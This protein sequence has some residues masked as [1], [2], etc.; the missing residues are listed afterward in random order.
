MKLHIILITCV[1]ATTPR[2]IIANTLSDADTA[3]FNDALNTQDIAALR[4]LLSKGADANRLM[5]NALDSLNVELL[6]LA[7][8]FNA[9]PNAQE[10]NNTALHILA[11]IELVDSEAFQ[12]QTNSQSDL[13]E[14]AIA[15]HINSRAHRLEMIDILVSKGANINA[16]NASGDTPISTAFATNQPMIVDYF[17]AKKADPNIGVNLFQK[18]SVA[19]ID[20]NYLKYLLDYGYRAT[21][22]N[23]DTTTPLHKL[24]MQTADKEKI[25]LL[26]EYGA[27]LNA[28]DAQGKTP[29]VASANTSRAN[30]A[31]VY[32]SLV[33]LGAT[34][35]PEYTLAQLSKA[36]DERDYVAALALLKQTPDVVNGVD[37]EGITPL[38][39]ASRGSLKLVRILLDNGANLNSQ[40]NGRSALDEARDNN[41]DYI[42]RYLLEQGIQ[43]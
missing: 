18:D 16:L 31:D 3:A 27:D 35:S 40:A 43:E 15:K 5:F 34:V 10:N 21:A 24:V 9:N 1:L 8:E 32:A 33:E 41:F 20:T 12:A 6:N 29:L 19:K 25:A 36:I 14:E 4:P 28:T 22:D 38:M 39:R 42:A 30:P 2:L 17:I 26:V 7:L 37:S 13:S 23:E 11:A